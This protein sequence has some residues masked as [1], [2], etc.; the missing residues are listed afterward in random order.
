MANFRYFADLADGSSIKLDPAKVYQNGPIATDNGRR[1]AGMIG[2][3][4]SEWIK[5]TRRVQYRSYMVKHE[6]DSRCFNANGRTM[7]CECACGGANHGKGAIERKE[8]I[9]SCEAV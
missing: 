1:P 4:G 3:T 9:I 7:N 2:W 8:A 5:I 6:C